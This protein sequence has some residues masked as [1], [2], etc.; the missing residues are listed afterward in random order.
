MA[1]VLLDITSRFNSLEAFLYDY[2]VAPAVLSTMQPFKESL[3]GNA[4]EGARILD[5]GCGGGQLAIEIAK[6]RKD[7]GITGV[8]LSHSQVK[9]ARSRG[10]EAGVKIDFIQASAMDI[11][12]AD[13]SFDLVYSVDCLKHWPEKPRGLMECIRLLKPGGM[14][15]I[16]E[17]NKDCTL[18]QGLRFVRNWRVPYVIRPFSV[19][20]F[21]LFAVLRSL[22]IEK[23]W[24]LA[25]KLPMDEITLE[26]NADGINWTI[27]AIKPSR[28]AQDLLRGNR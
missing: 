18:G 6:T 24:S 11:P 7:L 19:L 2:I 17:V 28:S 27:R 5:I 13:E 25:E 12:F 1:M 14:L 9:R 26:P 3:H 23:A 8:D 16:T 10:R 21:F 4:K 20:P 15:F 22:T